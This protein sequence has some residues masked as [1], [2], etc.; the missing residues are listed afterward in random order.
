MLNNP[1]HSTNEIAT[2]NQIILLPNQEEKGIIWPWYFKLCGYSHYPRRLRR[3]CRPSGP[4][5]YFVFSP[6]ILLQSQANS[7]PLFGI[8][9]PALSGVCSG[10]RFFFCPSTVSS[11]T[12][13]LLPFRCL[14]IINSMYFFRNLEHPPTGRA[15][16]ASERPRRPCG[17]GRRG[18]SAERRVAPALP[19]ARRP[20][21]PERIATAYALLYDDGGAARLRGR[22]RERTGRNPLRPSGLQF[23]NLC[24]NCRDPP[25][26]WAVEKSAPL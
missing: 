4:P 14:Y 13:R 5:H 20:A 1:Q 26:R 18:A 21:G 25:L 6:L 9:L 24:K 8:L 22:D 2:Q 17:W 11:Y 15:S 16:A 19:G 7:K 3:G 10:R 23:V 12:G